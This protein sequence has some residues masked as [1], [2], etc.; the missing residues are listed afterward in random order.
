MCE[1]SE[2]LISMYVCLWLTL[3]KL[4]VA[5]GRTLLRDAINSRIYFIYWTAWSCTMNLE[6]TVT[7]QFS[8]A[9]V[10]AK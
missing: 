9:I 7:G 3:V 8:H 1:R 2:K 10:V 4:V 6:E 5:V